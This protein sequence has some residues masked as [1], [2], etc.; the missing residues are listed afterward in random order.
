MFFQVESA[1]N[2]SKFCLK[3]YVAKMAEKKI[4]C[5]PCCKALGSVNH[6]AESIFLKLKDRGSLNQHRVS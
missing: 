1:E 4:L 6:Q 5:M 3:G 2:F